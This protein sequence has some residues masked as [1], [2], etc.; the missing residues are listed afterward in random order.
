[1]MRKKLLTPLIIGCLYIQLST[2][3]MSNPT[4]SS[5]EDNFT[6]AISQHP[7]IV[8]ATVEMDSKLANAQ[9]MGKPL[10]NPELGAELESEGSNT[11]V[12]VGLSQ[13]ID[14]WNKQ[15]VSQQQGELS[16]VQA[17]YNFENMLQSYYA[18]GLRSLVEWESAKNLVQLTQTQQQQQ[19][20]ILELIEKRQQAGDLGQVDADL[21]YLGLTQKVAETATTKVELKRSQVIIEKIFPAMTSPGPIPQHLWKRINTLAE[22]MDMQQRWLETHPAIQVAK[23]GWHMQKQAS[24]LIKLEAKADPVFGVEAGTSGDDNV[25]AVTFSMPLAI[26]NDFSSNIKAANQQALSV[27]AN[28]H[29]VMKNQATELQASYAILQE[30]AKHYAEWQS[31][32]DGR[33]RQSDELLKRLWDSAEISTM[34]YISVLQQ[35]TEALAAGIELRK[36]LDLSRIDWLLST[37]QI[38]ALLTQKEIN[39]Q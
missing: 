4:N 15:S 13:S 27:E 32:I 6:Q 9:S 2:N 37:G 3:A 12:R 5:W 23:T 19:Q 38:S 11:N 36:Q 16:R 21:A 25:F 1:M 33:R 10:Y 18:K 24:Q 39:G 7:D 14:W 35:G 29:M 22:K 34:E 28:F 31:M 26:R 8:A 17:R 30:Y 20:R